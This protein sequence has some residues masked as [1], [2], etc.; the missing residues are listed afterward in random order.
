MGGGLQY[1]TGFILP[2]TLSEFQLYCSGCHFRTQFADL[3]ADH[4][5]ANPVHYSA[6]CHTR[7]KSWSCTC[8]PV[9]YSEQT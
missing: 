5:L 4:L 6:T 1:L 3:M 8:T 7:S 9:S 2:P